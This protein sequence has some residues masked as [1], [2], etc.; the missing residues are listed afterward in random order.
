[1]SPALLAGILEQSRVNNPPRGIT[2]LLCHTS[3]VFAQ[4]LEGGR[5]E[6]SEL[7]GR[8]MRDTRH[9]NVTLLVYEEIKERSF[10][11]WSMGQVNV[12]A[13]NPGLLLRYS[14]RPKF[15]PEAGSGESA[16]SLLLELIATGAIGC[17]AKR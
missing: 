4:V 11:G 8:L 12:D 17:Q 15:D 1:M 6:V 14:N 9:R 16:M 7:L 5:A 13:V 3:E 2:G 10:A